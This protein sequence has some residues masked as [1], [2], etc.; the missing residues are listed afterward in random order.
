MVVTPGGRDVVRPARAA[1][2]TVLGGV[3]RAATAPWTRPEN[4][5]VIPWGMFTA[6]EV[7]LCTAGGAGAL[8]LTLVL[9]GRLS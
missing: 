1:D 9:L 5:F 8:F 6:A 2:R 4:E 7:A 3:C